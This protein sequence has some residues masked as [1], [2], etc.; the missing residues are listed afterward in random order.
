MLG[1]AQNITYVPQ[2]MYVSWSCCIAKRHVSFSCSG[3]SL[4]YWCLQVLKPE[5]VG[6]V[7]NDEIWYVPKSLCCSSEVV[8]AFTP[9]EFRL[10][11]F[12]V[13]TSV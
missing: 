3:H 4:Q 6:R 9:I 2:H 8:P 1:I 5:G 7:S 13:A 11:M 12:H 10:G